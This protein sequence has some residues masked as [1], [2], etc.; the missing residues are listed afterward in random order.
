MPGYHCMA[1]GGRCHPGYSPMV[2]RQS[3]SYVGL[4]TCMI[5]WVPLY[6]RRGRCHL[7]YSPMVPSQSQSYVGLCTCMNALV[8]IGEYPR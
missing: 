3:Q 7:G 8:T 2:P 6:G 5:A 4:C 1:E